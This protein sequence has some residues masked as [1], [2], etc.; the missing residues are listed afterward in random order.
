MVGGTVVRRAGK[1]RIISSS[2]SIIEAVEGARTMGEVVGRT[3][4]FS[5]LGGAAHS[6]GRMKEGR[7]K[8]KRKAGRKGSTKTDR[9]YRTGIARGWSPVCGGRSAGEEEDENRS[10]SSSNKKMSVEGERGEARERGREK[11]EESQ[12]WAA[13]TAP[14]GSL[15]NF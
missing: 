9:N 6:R 12:H 7:R 2:S 15:I 10:S 14:T 11:E 8:G 1:T 4:A 5:T 3:V 13:A